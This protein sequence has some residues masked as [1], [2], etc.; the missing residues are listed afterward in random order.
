LCGETPT[1]ETHRNDHRQRDHTQA[2]T[3][4][5]TARSRTGN[6]DR[7]I[8]ALTLSGVNGTERKRP[9]V[10]LSNARGFVFVGLDLSA[11]RG[12]GVAI[13]QLIS[14]STLSQTHWA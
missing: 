13:V 8:A 5:R 3:K 12:C 1:N 4:H 10:M 7:T 11:N 9:P 2:D 6:H 14:G